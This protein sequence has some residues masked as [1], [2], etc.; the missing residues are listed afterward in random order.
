[1][2][3]LSSGTAVTGALCT[4]GSPSTLCFEASRA[5]DGGAVAVPLLV[6]PPGQM[7]GW[8]RFRLSQVLGPVVPLYLF[9][10][11]VSCM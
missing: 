6:V 5:G 1:M 4:D 11:E 10:C 9:L 8:D 2:P 7:S 3:P